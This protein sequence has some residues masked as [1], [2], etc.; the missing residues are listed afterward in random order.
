MKGGWAAFLKNRQWINSY[1][2][3]HTTHTDTH[4][5]NSE[6]THGSEKQR[7]K[8]KVKLVAQLLSVHQVG[9]R[10]FPTI[11]LCL[12]TNDLMESGVG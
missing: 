2:H 7:R 4:V 12:Q 6:K 3:T 9:S 5:A 8:F 1:T 10:C 11:P